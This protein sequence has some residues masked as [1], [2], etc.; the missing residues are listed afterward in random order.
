MRCKKPYVVAV[1]SFVNLCDAQTSLSSGYWLLDTPCLT[2][3]LGE[4][5]SLP[6]KLRYTASTASQSRCSK[7]LLWCT[8]CQMHRD[9]LEVVRSGTH[10][11]T[12]EASALQPGSSKVNQCT[13]QLGA[14]NGIHY[15]NANTSPGVRISLTVYQSS[16]PC[17]ASVPL[18]L[19]TRLTRMNLFSCL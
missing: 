17:F 3:G 6:A 5:L 14:G 15:N 12:A 4:E 18:P 10:G 16:D 7:F 9:R 1:A 8:R 19:E 13:S 2:S 11:P